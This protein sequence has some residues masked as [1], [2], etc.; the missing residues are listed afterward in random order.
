MGWQIIIVGAILVLATAYLVHRAWSAL[1]HSTGSCSGCHS[2]PCA[3]STQ[4]GETLVELH[5]SKLGV[6]PEEPH[7]CE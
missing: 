7:P 3:P 1:R 4:Q 6:S 5:T 2:Q